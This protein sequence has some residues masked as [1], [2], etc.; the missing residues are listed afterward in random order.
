MYRGFLSGRE[1]DPQGARRSID[2]LEKRSQGGELTV[3]YA[4]FVHYAL[5]EMD[6]VVACM[7]EPFRW[8][9]LPLMELQYSRL[10]AG[11]RSDPRIVDH[12][13]SQLELSRPLH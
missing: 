11:P 6:A 3:F 8:H 13:R 5:G 7:E 12:L 9:S 10:H 2:Q 1:G 4:G